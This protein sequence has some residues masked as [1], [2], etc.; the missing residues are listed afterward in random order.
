MWDCALG[1][2][3]EDSLLWELPRGR[4]PLEGISQGL[5]ERTDSE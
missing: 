4:N 2:K 5:E 3:K 1:E